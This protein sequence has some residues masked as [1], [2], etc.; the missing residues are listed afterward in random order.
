MESETPP[1]AS[2]PPRSDDP[3]VS[4]QRISPGSG[5]V[6]EGTK[7]TL[8]DNALA[9]ENMRGATLMETGDGGPEL[10]DLWP[11]IVP[12][13]PTALEPNQQPPL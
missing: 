8:E 4:S 5:E 11:D 6:W 10:S 13:T 12:E 3:E 7:T 9:A 2:P 1:Q